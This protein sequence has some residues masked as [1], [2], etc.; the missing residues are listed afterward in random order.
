MSLSVSVYTCSL[1][2]SL[3]LA[4]ARA[5]PSLLFIHTDTSATG[6]H[7]NEVR[8]GPQYPTPAAYVYLYI[9]SAVTCADACCTVYLF[10]RSG[11]LSEQSFPPAAPLWTPIVLHAISGIPPP[12][13][14]VPWTRMALLRAAT[15]G[16]PWTR[17]AL[18]RAATTGVPWTRMAL[19]LSLIH[20]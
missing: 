3:S 19:L 11:K 14:G 13:T 20:I 10:G 18:L 16:V 8:E 17:M 9:H 15:T 2:L 12:L 5:L 6:S 4:R 1:S 7:S